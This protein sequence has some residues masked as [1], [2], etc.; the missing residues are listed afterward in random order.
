[1]NSVSITHY[2]LCYQQFSLEILSSEDVSGRRSLSV[3]LAILNSHIGVLWSSNH[4]PSMFWKCL[5]FS[6]LFSRTT[7]QMLLCNKPS[8][9]SGEQHVSGNM[10]CP[11]CHLILKADFFFQYVKKKMLC[12]LTCR[13]TFKMFSCSNTCVIYHLC[14]LLRVKWQF[15]LWKESC[16]RVISAFPLESQS[17]WCLHVHVH[18]FRKLIHHFDNIFHVSLAPYP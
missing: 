5:P 13:V 17:A 1:M 15:G 9:A 6:K 16:R 18:S 10:T 14:K 12:P 7:S 4:L 8:G 11:L 3:R 2:W